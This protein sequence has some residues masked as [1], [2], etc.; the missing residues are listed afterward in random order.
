[1][2]NMVDMEMFQKVAWET[3]RN[4]FFKDNDKRLRLGRWLGSKFSSSRSFM[5]THIQRLRSILCLRLFNSNST[6]CNC[7]T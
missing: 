6:R 4:L 7:T 5:I 3:V 2:A 1:M